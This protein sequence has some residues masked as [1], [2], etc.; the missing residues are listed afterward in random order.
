MQTQQSRPSIGNSS[1][2]PWR[3]PPPPPHS[4]H[5]ALIWSIV[6]VALGWA[7]LLWASSL[8]LLAAIQVGMLGLGAIGTA[9]V[10][11]VYHVARR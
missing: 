9:I 1:P 6:L 3:G 7:C 8:P 2:P 10:V 4:S 5:A 11:G